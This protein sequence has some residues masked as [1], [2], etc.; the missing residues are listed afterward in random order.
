MARLLLTW[1]AADQMSAKKGSE[2]WIQ[3]AATWRARA[4]LPRGRLPKGNFHFGQTSVVCFLFFFFFPY[5]NSFTRIGF[6]S[7]FSPHFLQVE[8]KTKTKQTKTKTT[9]QT[10]RKD[11]LKRE[12][13]FPSAKPNLKAHLLSKNKKNLAFRT[14]TNS[15]VILILSTPYS[16]ICTA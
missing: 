3:G 16:Q 13:S 9:P 4:P 7:Y 10:K 11:T 5:R 6:S 2:G 15:G 1:E 12:N 8:K 14:K